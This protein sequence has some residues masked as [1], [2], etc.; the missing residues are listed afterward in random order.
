[1]TN[2]NRFELINAFPWIDFTAK[3]AGTDLTVV[4]PRDENQ[5]N[6]L[7][8]PD[9]HERKSRNVRILNNVNLNYKFPKFVEADYKYG[10]ELWNSDYSDLYKNQEAAPQVAAGF[11][12]PVSQGS[13][14]LDYSRS[15]YQ[16][17]LATIY[18]KT[19][20]EKDFHI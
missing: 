20:F 18:F 8:E 12:G 6:V 5:L 16:N 11:W 4:R 15:L 17:S 14:R 9:W 13:I 10:I 3:Y 1:G 2:N 19:D 7:S